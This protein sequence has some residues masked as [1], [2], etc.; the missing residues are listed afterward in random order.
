METETICECEK[1]KKLTKLAQDE[2]QPGEALIYSGTW[3]IATALGCLPILIGGFSLF[4]GSMMLI[5]EILLL[6]GTTRL[7]I[8]IGS[9]LLI[10]IGAGLFLLGRHLNSTNNNLIFVSN[11]RMGLRRYLFSKNYSNRDILIDSIENVTIIFNPDTLLGKTT[12]SRQKQTEYFLTGKEP[13]VNVANHY[14][15][16][17]L[18]NKKTPMRITT[19]HLI[20]MHAALQAA[21]VAQQKGTNAHD[22]FRQITKG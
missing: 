15:S 13:D 2:M 16:I 7:N 1:C 10:I 6:S 21:I 22:E 14:I 19:L 4:I 8:M 11:K 17:K 12:S 18:K 3:G 5:N 9:I 20:T